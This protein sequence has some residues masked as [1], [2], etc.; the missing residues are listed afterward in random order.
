MSREF[1]NKEGFLNLAR[2]NSTPFFVLDSK[3]L[4]ENAVQFSSTAKKYFP[5][6]KLCYSVK[7]NSF[8]S[9]LKILYSNGFGFDIASKKELEAVSSFN[10]FKVFNSPAKS[11]EDIKT[12]VSQNCLIVADSFSELEKIPQGTEIGL[13]LNFSNNKFGFSSKQF[14]L[15]LKKSKSLELKPVLLHSHPGTNVSLQKYKSF[16]QQLKRHSKD[17]QFIDFGGGFPCNSKLW[18]EYFS[19]IKKVFGSSLKNKTIVLEPGRAIVE[20]AMYL[21]AKVVVV[22]ELN[23]KNLAVLDA[24]INLLPKISLSGFEFIT[25]SESGSKKDFQ[26]VGPLLFGNDVLATIKASLKENDL[27]LVKNVGAYCLQLSWKIS[28]KEPKVLEF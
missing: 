5:N 13:R 15:A 2:Q 26:L 18:A 23:G 8:L 19:L 27:I 14:P 16:L 21:V 6:H 11:K 22:K 25:F 12:A 7:T 9:V 20:D 24:G 10:C 3:K 28:F 1:A 17:F 4:S